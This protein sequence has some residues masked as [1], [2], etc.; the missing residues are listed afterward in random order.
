MRCGDRVPKQDSNNSPGASKAHCKLLE[1]S[2]ATLL[3]PYV[4]DGI[5]RVNSMNCATERI[6]ARAVGERLTDWRTSITNF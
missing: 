1:K 4:E 2:T 6:S 5:R 3:A